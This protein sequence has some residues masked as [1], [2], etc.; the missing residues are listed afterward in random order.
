MSIDEIQIW[1]WNILIGDWNGDG[2]ACFARL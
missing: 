2:I 1:I